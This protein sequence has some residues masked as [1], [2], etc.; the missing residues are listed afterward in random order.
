MEPFSSKSCL[1]KRAV[2]MLTP[3]AANTI[4]KSSSPSVSPCLRLGNFTRPPWRTICAAI[5]NIYSR[6][7][8]I[9][10][11]YAEDQQQRKLGFFGPEQCYSSHQLPKY[12]FGSFL[13]DKYATPDLSAINGRKGMFYCKYFNLSVDVQEVFCQ[14]FWAFVN[15]FP[16]TVENSAK[17][18]FR[19]GCSQNGA[20]EFTNRIFRINSGG[21]FENLHLC[22]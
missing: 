17:H 7:M 2:S 10:L 12:Q 4:A 14:H 22:K 5:L 21:A 8:L 1:K 18:A 20:S 6:I 13:R 11:H 9:L 15:G 3:M 16:R 19:D